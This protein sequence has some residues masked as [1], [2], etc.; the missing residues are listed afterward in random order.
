MRLPAYDGKAGGIDV[1]VVHHDVDDYKS[2]DLAC[3]VS[4]NH[5]P[6]LA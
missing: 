1:N 5:P 3:H 2:N 6:S 4:A